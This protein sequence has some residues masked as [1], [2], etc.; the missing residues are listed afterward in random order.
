MNVP[1]LTLLVKDT[2]GK[3]KELFQKHSGTE[4]H[5]QPGKEYQN[6]VTELDKSLANFLQ[7]N[8]PY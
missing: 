6:K 7:S 3:Q 1:I 2:A 8:K 5:S 4:I